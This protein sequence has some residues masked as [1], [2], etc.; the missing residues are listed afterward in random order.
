M[1]VPSKTIIGAEK[2]RP[3]IST[4][5]CDRCGARA[6]MRATLTDKTLLFCGHHA[7]EKL[8]ALTQS[9][10]RTEFEKQNA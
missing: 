4:E 10:W 5:K 9:G 8:S 3:K 6:T 7:V 1:A 2:L